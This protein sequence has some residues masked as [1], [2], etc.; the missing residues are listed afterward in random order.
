MDERFIGVYMTDDGPIVLGPDTSR[1]DL[2][3]VVRQL[4]QELEHMRRERSK[5]VPRWLAEV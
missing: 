1:E 5:L 4:A 3:F 2:L